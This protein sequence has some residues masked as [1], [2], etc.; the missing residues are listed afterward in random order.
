VARRAA[1]KCREAYRKAPQY[2]VRVNRIVKRAKADHLIDK[3][4]AGH[5]RKS[6]NQRQ[7]GDGVERAEAPCDLVVG[8]LFG[9]KI[10]EIGHHITL[11]LRGVGLGGAVPVEDAAAGDATPDGEPPAVSLMP[12]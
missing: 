6:R 3:P 4:G 8:D 2:R 12:P 9:E 5:D 11:W 10:Q 1:G 7:F